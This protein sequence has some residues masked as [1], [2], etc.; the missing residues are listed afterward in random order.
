[1]ST[2]YVMTKSPGWIARLAVV[3]ALLSLAAGPAF[4]QANKFSFGSRNQKKMIK[5]ITLI[6]EEGDIDGAREILESINLARAKPYGRARIHQMLGTLAAQDE[7][8]ELALDHLE[9][10]VAEE[11]LQPED[12]L[13]SL[14]LVGQL[15]TMLERYEDAIVTL[16]SWI[17]QVETPAPS[18]YYTLAVT[19][20]QAERPEDS[21]ATIKK[22][23]ELSSNP[24]E[25]WYRLLL[26]L[27][28]ERSE[29]KEALALLDDIILSYPKQA[30]WSQMAAI[31][32]Q[33]DDMS[34]SLAV[35]QLAKSEGFVTES[36]DLT[37]IA[38]MFMVEG[39]PHRGAAVMRQGLEDGSIEETEQSYQTLSDTLLQSREWEEALDPL[40]KAAELHENGALFVRHAQVNLQLG[41]WADAR[42]SLNLAFEKGGLVDEGQAHILFGIA[43]ANDKEWKAAI[44]AFLRA[45]KFDGTRDVAGKWI[46]YV[47]RERARLGEG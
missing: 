43:A 34:R 46:S 20:Y 5:V 14:Y 6:Q 26:S 33:L 44:A 30:Y 12:H 41:R 11:A 3:G 8:F 36:R 32:A 39:L 23:V 21:L 1:M 29:Y 19:Y 7:Q 2:G 9:K 42:T 24:R 28:L 40:G 47:E 17:S 10:C 38:Q 25:P 45:R 16:E 4:A 27:H 15:Q 18:S 22:A 37:R 35:Q 31:Y 13:R